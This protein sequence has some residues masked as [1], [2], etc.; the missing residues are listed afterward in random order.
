MSEIISTSELDE[1]EWRQL[2]VRRGSAFMLPEWFHACMRHYG[3]AQ[4]EVVATRAAD[5]SL[6]GVMPLVRRGRSLRFAGASLGDHFG[7]V[8]AEADEGAAAAAVATALGRGD[9]LVLDHVDSGAAWPEAIQQAA[10]GSLR[11][12]TS[13]TDV[14][15]RID[16]EGLTWDGYLGSRSRNFRSQVRGKARKLEREHAV[17]YRQTR[18]VD[19]LDRDMSTFFALH[20]ARWGPRGGSSIPTE[21]SRAFHRDFAAALL[22]RGWLRLWFLEIEGEPV[23]TWYGWNVGGRYAYYL[24]GFAP[25]WQERSVGF[26][27]LAQT[28]R[29]AIEEGAREYD[30]L[31]G[32]ETYKA[33]FATHQQ[34]VE[35]LVL[36]PAASAARLLASLEAAAWR[37]SRQLPDPVRT[38]GKRIYEVAG[39]LMPTA[40]SR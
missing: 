10:P 14:L 20:D 36:A 11:R 4:P 29:A 22:A 6:A 13:R 24:A 18:D 2:A 34:E 40:R 35:T 7:P 39:R 27:L 32:D 3:N 1:D 9:H 23:A 33:R 37:R 15:P 12:A 8:A 5:R 25:R 16:I 28:I 26:V 17:S 19:E 21:S 38:A 31:R 30:L